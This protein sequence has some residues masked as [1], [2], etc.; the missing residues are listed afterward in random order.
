MLYKYASIEIVCNS[1]LVSI[2]LA[3]HG[4]VINID[5]AW[6]RNLR[7]VSG[8]VYTRGESLQSGLEDV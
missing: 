2:I 5:W 4:S 3:E 6:M 8:I 7:R 1:S